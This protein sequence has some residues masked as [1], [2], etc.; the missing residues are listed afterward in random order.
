M[1]SLDRTNTNFIG[2]WW[3]KIDRWV[4]AAILL[5]MTMG[6]LLITAA[7]P[8]VA[9]Q[10][11]WTSFHFIKKHILFLAPTVGILIG[12]SFLSL[13]D[14]KR[15]AIALFCASLGGVILTIFMGVEVKGASRWLDIGGFSLQPSEFIKP[16]FAVVSAMIF[17]HHKSH[18]EFPGYIVGM[19]LY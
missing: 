16:T 13:P 19:A 8:A 12:T 17:A 5:L 15:L 18:P 6:V 2:Q 14:I 10:H 4:L 3:W 1:L 7:S 11:H 9:I